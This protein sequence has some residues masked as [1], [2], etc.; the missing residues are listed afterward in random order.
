MAEGEEFE[1]SRSRFGHGLFS[2]K[3]VVDYAQ[4]ERPT[5]MKRLAKAKCSECGGQVRRARELIARLRNSLN[6]KKLKE[7]VASALASQ[8]RVEAAF[9]LGAQGAEDA[10][11]AIAIS[12]GATV[13]N[14]AAPALALAGKDQEALKLADELAK[15]HPQDDFVLSVIVPT[16]HAIAAMNHGEAAK[17]IELLNAAVPYDRAFIEGRLVRGDAYLRA[18]RGSDAAQEFQS[19]LAMKNGFPDAPLIPLYQLGLARTYALQGDKA[20]AR[21]AYQDFFAIWKDADPDIPILKEAKTEY[22]KLQ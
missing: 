7:G 9:G 13:L 19:V 10:A 22:A 11:A 17:A 18:G 6:R 3:A 2:S 12:R 4:Q 5:D 15:L 14:D 21:T 16:V 1:P 8:A 20:K